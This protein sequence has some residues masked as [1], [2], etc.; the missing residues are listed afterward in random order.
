VAGVA[1]GLGEHFVVDP[2][3]FRILFVLLSFAGGL[4]LLLYVAGWFLI[5][6]TGATQRPAWDALVHVQRQPWRAWVGG[7]LVVVAVLVT[8]GNLHLAHQ[9]VLWG[10]ALLA[11][12]VLLLVQERWQPAS[13]HVAPQPVGPAAYAAASFPGSGGTD[14]G[15]VPWA[16][17]RA[18]RERSILGVVTVAAA[19]LAVGVA[20]LLDSAGVVSVSLGIG[21]AIALIIV[22]GGL[23]A[24]TWFGRS[25]ALIVVG[26]LLLPFTVAAMLVREPLIGGTGDV[27]ASPVVLADVQSQYHLVAGQLTVDLTRVPFGGSSPTVTATVALGQ[28][29]LVVPPGLNVDVRGHVGAGE[30]DLLGAIDDGINIDSTASNSA[31]G[32]AGTLHLD[33][34]V[35]FGQ[36]RVVSSAAAADS[37]S[38]V[39]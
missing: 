3:I 6:E 8:A 31:A 1:G 5:P 4:G 29:T 20:A 38:P 28:L 15:A 10:I 12:G 11:V 26:I 14:A 34:S 37:P 9:G 13:T 16:P 2:V 19:L 39:P 35:G 7:I 21:A 22:G 17:V 18:T 30:I 25:R 24:G 32:S 23:V 27:S 33:L 36:I